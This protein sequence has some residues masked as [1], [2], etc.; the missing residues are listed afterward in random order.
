MTAMSRRDDLKRLLVIW[1]FVSALVRAFFPMRAL[2]FSIVRLIEP[3]RDSPIAI[4]VV[5]ASARF[6]LDWSHA[7][8]GIIK[9]FRMA[10]RL[11]KLA[12]GA[13]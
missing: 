9:E 3:A 4:L 10:G 12:K 6:A 5:A 2:A 13:R 11:V 8:G 7:F 1:F